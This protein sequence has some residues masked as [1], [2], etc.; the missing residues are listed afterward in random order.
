MRTIHSWIAGL[1]SKVSPTPID[2]CEAGVLVPV[3]IVLDQIGE[4]ADVGLPRRW[5]EDCRSYR[6]RLQIY[7]QEEI[8]RREK[9]EQYLRLLLSTER[10]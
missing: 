2:E 1:A 6:L 3:Q 8:I 4:E 10:T 7:C 5:Q 9:F